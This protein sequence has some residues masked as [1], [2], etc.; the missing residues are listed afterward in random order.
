M[1]ASFAAAADRP[2]TTNAAPA[3]ATAD[4]V[5][6]RDAAER[7][8]ASRLRIRQA[9]H[10]HA[11]PVPSPSLFADGLDNVGSRLLDRIKSLPMAKALVEGLTAWW[12]HHPLHRAANAVD[13][14]SSQLIGPLARRKPGAV[15]L[16]AVGSGVL[17]AYARP[18][19][20]LVRPTSLLRAMV[21]VGRL[22]S[23]GPSARA[24]RNAVMNGSADAS[25]A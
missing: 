22:A 6:A 14:A 16:I 24:W 12:R 1:S 18:W 7:L 11:H 9:L 20:W 2:P 15:L 10:S 8:A 23:G 19:R 21:Q 5:G 4:D 17:L 3:P 25:T 13:A